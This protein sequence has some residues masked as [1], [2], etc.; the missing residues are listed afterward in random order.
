MFDLASPGSRKLLKNIR[1]LFFVFL[2]T[3]LLYFFVIM[4]GAKIFERPVKQSDIA[5]MFEYLEMDKELPSEYVALWKKVEVASIALE[6]VSYDLSARFSKNGRYLDRA[7]M[8]DLISGMEMTI[9]SQQ[10]ESL[11]LLGYYALRDDDPFK[12]AIALIT[13]REIYS[14][15]YSVFY[16]NRVINTDNNFLR[17]IAVEI[18]S[19]KYRPKGI[20]MALMPKN[21][22]RYFGG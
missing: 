13:L 6:R 20:K 21:L 8:E 3:P 1:L 9:A 19:G 15:K 16:A 14:K 11:Y 12:Q 5:A 2:F 10:K 17:S 4:V 18:V 22:N 7:Y